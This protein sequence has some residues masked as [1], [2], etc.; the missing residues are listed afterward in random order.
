MELLKL[1]I[2]A[3]KSLKSI[4]MNVET[5]IISNMTPFVIFRNDEISSVVKFILEKKHSKVYGDEGELS[6][7]QAAQIR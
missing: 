3:E 5:F 7:F 6:E 2:A 1:E 4:K